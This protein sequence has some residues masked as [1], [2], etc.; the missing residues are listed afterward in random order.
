MSGTPK[1][2]KAEADAASRVAADRFRL[3]A[4]EDGL[5]DV[6]I[7]T[8]PSPVGE[9]LVAVTRRGLAAIAFDDDSR[10]ELVERLADELSPRVV[11]AA[12]PTDETRRELEEYFAGSR[13]RFELRLDRRLMHPFAKQVLAATARVPFGE[14]TTYGTIATRIGH[15]SAARAVGA[16]LGSNPIPIVV[17]CHRVIGAGGKLTGYAGGLHRKEYLLELEGAMAPRLG[18]E[19]WTS[20]S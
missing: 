2:S 17:P 16:A 14:V 8:M 11:E 1:I 6:A 7:A 13:E 19:P 15:P 4:D 9:L 18:T 10:D 3:A 5:V 12:R 20:T